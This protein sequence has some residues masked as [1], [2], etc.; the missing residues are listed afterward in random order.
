MHPLADQSDVAGIIP[1][2]RSLSIF[3]RCRT[4]ALFANPAGTLNEHHRKQKNLRYVPTG[5]SYHVNHR[6]TPADLG[7]W[8]MST[9]R[10]TALPE[11]DAGR[12]PYTHKQGAERL[13]L[14]FYELQP[15]ES[16]RT[17]QSDI[18]WLT[19]YGLIREHH[20]P[21]AR[22]AERKL[23]LVGGQC[24]RH[25]E[26]ASHSS[27]VTR[28][29]TVC[30]RHYHHHRPRCRCRCGPQLRFE[31][32]RH[33]RPHFCHHWPVC[34]RLIDCLLYMRLPLS[35]GPGFRVECAWGPPRKGNT[36][37]VRRIL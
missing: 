4:Q 36:N 17:A 10:G 13:A 6:T 31:C 18:L 11:K 8:D 24:V 33:R 12:K 32:L 35:S 3:D 14:W 1:T 22:V 37:P 19:R 5:N 2:M 21:Y 28:L 20:S 25:Y 9:Q 27:G 34:P 26:I 7:Y 29:W 30:R 23:V 16:H 15:P